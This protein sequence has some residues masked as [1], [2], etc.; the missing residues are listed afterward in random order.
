VLAISLGVAVLPLLSRYAN[1]GDAS[2]LRDSLNRALRLAF[3]EGLVTGAGL[4][5][6]AEPILRLLFELRK[7]TRGDAVEAA[8]VLRF[9]AAGLWAI[10]SYQIVARTFYALKDVITPLKISCGV[11]FL[12]QLLVVVLV[13]V[14]GLGPG[15]FG[16]A[17]SIAA[18]INTVV[19]LAIL[20]R[21]IGRIGGRK[22]LA[23][24]ARAVA[25]TAAMCAAILALRWWLGD[26]RSAVTVGV[27]IPA[28]A[29][30]FL[31]VLRLLRAPELGELFGAMRKAK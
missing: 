1:R 18:G 16:L 14:P 7:F 31:A 6:L 20:R 9:Y 23:S 24:I 4:F 28:G 17:T 26:V 13:W 5:L 25:A 8:H 12:N 3:L 22:L 29:A 19:L 11:V 2:N 30:V 10:C 21:R 27:C 15:A